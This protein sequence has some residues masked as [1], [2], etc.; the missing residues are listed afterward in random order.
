[1]NAATQPPRGEAHKA[2]AFSGLMI[3]AEMLAAPMA[4]GALKS[5]AAQ[6][7]TGR[8][9]AKV[10]GDLEAALAA[11]W[12]HLERP[13]QAPAPAIYRVTEEGR[14]ELE[15]AAGRMRAAADRLRLTH[16]RGG[17]DAATG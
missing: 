11:G 16:A 13:A 7:G 8:S 2:R 4:G 3:A 1:M 17:D 15:R 10:R 12:L 9:W 14:A 5:Y 6:I